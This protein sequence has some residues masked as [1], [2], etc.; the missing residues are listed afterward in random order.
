MK[1]HSCERVLSNDPKAKN[2][3]LWTIGELR[4]AYCAPL[5]MCPGCGC[6]WNEPSGQCPECGSRLRE[7]VGADFTNDCMRVTLED[8]R[9][10][11]S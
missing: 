5:M 9:E 8:H 3:G 6:G 1:C 4:W 10:A 7:S 11:T 2:F